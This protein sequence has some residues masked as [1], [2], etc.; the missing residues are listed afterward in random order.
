MHCAKLGQASLKV[1]SG[2]SSAAGAPSGVAVTA[3]AAVAEGAAKAKP[4]KAGL[5]LGRTDAAGSGVSAT[6]KPVLTVDVPNV[7]SVQPESFVAITAVMAAM[8]AA[9]TMPA[10]S[11]RAARDKG[12]FVTAAQT[13]A[14]HAVTG[15][16]AQTGVT[17]VTVFLAMQSSKIRHWP[18]RRPWLR[19]WEAKH[20][21]WLARTG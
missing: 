21:L 17:G 3:G 15:R 6:L 18:T 2:Q 19:P 20:L 13:A 10:I 8:K 12:R 16:N 5:M 9:A 11:S 1:N 14:V 4:L 7:R